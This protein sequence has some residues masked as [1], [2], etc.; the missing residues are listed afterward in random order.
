[1]PQRKTSIAVIA[2]T[3]GL[4]LEASPFTATAPAVQS[5]TRTVYV[6]VLDKKGQP[7]T[8]LQGNEFE[9]KEGGKTQQ[10]VSAQI[11]TTPL[12]VAVLVSDA[13]TGAFQA[14]LAHFMQTLLGRAEFA[15]TSVVVQPERFVDFTGDAAALSAAVR[16]FGP[17]GRLVG[18]QLMEAIQQA[19]KDVKAEGK[20]AVIVVLRVGAEDNSTIPGDDVREQL[21]KSGAILYVVSTVGAQRQPASQARQGISTEQAQLRDS[22]VAEGALNLGQVLGDGSKDSG[23]RH[24]QVVS[25]SLIEAMKGLGAELLQQYEVTYVLPEGTKPSEKISVSSKRRGV[26][27]R[28]PSRIPI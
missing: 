27:V 2:V 18:A 12:R 7:V 1:M 8:D 4:A 21:R 10:V 16:R 24:D 20:R 17:R 22:E 26:T 5:R 11:A 6:S 3:A 19:I 14:G 28:A 15:L 25:T 13:G 9:I 23:G